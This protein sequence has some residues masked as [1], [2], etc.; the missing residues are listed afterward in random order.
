MVE[1][2]RELAAA[3]RREII[4]LLWLIVFGEIQKCGIFVNYCL[5]AKKIEDDNICDCGLFVVFRVV[6]RRFCEGLGFYI[7]IKTEAV[8][9]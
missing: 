7:V 3:A 6:W 5:V 9:N 1:K 8:W 2:K 4:T